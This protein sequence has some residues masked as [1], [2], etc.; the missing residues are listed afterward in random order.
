MGSKLITINLW[1]KNIPG[2]VH[3]NDIPSVSLYLVN[4]KKINPAIIICPGG[5]YQRRAFH[6]G[7]PVALW[8]NSIGISGIVLNYRVSPVNYPYPLIDALRALKLLRFNSEKLSIDPKRIGLMGFSAGGHLAA[9]AANHYDN[10]IFTDNE[11]KK[12]S[13]RPDVLVLCYPVI[14]FTQYVHNISMESLIG[15]NN[16]EKL[17]FLLSNELF[18]KKNSP[19]VF[20][21]HTAADTSVPVENSLIYINSLRKFNINFE[22]HIFSYGRHGLGIKDEVSEVKIWTRLFENW[23]KLIKFI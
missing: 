20:I 10:K 3:D 12:I 18:V 21:W 2:D 17:K 5:A 22:S 23:L 4:N 7:E 14:S 19:P 8:L 1:D 6:E 15:K 9:A 11:F 13:A 16:D